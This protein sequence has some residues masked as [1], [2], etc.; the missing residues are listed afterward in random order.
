[1]AGDAE[2]KVGSRV[3]MHCTIA[4]PNGFEALSTFGEAPLR[5]VMGDGTL[6]EGFEMALYGL[7]AGDR[8]TIRLDAA[9]AY[10]HRD[11]DKIR[12]MR[13]ADFPPD[14][15]TKPGTLVAFNDPSG[16]EFAGTIL[17]TEEDSL[18]VDFNHPLAG[19]EV[20]FTVQIVSISNRDGDHIPAS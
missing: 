7:K 4:L 18:R 6:A 1:M 8:Q 10:G 9:H 19:R 13:Q 12:L 20:I 5:F 16:T 2:I 11:P 3:E 17:A 15:T 14:V